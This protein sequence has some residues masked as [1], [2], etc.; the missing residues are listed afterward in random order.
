MFLRLGGCIDLGLRHE[1]DAAQAAPERGGERWSG[2]TGEGAGGWLGGEFRRAR[3]M[4]ARGGGGGGGGGVVDGGGGGGGA[5]GGGEA[6][7][8]G[9]GLVPAAGDAAAERDGAGGAGAGVHGARAD[10]PAR[11]G[12]GHARPRHHPPLR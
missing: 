10:A 5:G 4:A 1:L 8:G 9:V 12:A 2:L 7:P 6:E 3:E 11:G